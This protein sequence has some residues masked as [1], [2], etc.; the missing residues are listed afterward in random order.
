MKFSLLTKLLVSICLVSNATGVPTVFAGTGDGDIESTV[1]IQIASV[2]IS[3]RTLTGPNTTAQRRAGRILLPVAAVA[4]ALGDVLEVDAAARTIAVHRQTGAAAD[5]DAR[6][7]RIRE[8]GAIV[9][10]VSNGG[11][12]AFTPNVDSFLIPAEIA[13]S[14]FDIAIRYDSDKN[15][16]IVD[17]GQVQTAP[18]QTKGD[19]R[20][21][22]LYQLDYEYNLNQYGS[23]PSHDLILNA[24]GRIGDGRFTFTS[25]SGA[26]A[27]DGVALRR[28]NFTLDRPNGQQYIAG[29][30]GT[31]ANLQFLSAGIRGASARVYV[32]GATLTAF[33]GR[34]YSGLVF[35][36][37]DPLI[38][39]DQQNRNQ[40]ARGYDTSVFG[41]SATT[42]PQVGG[43]GAKPFYFSAGAL[44]FSSAN[45]KGE[46]VTGAVNYDTSRL[47][48]QADT[49]YGKFDARMANGS[50]VRGYGAAVDVSGTF[51]LRDDLA[52]Q[53]RFTS[54]SRNFLGP[55]VGLREPLNLQA[56]GV[57]WSPLKWFST[58]INGS[59]ARRPGDNTQNN[60]YLTASFNITPGPASPRFSFSHTESSTSQ[61]RSAQ[62]T[63]FNA[64]QDFRRLRVYLNV[65]RVRNN[66]PATV[67]SQV[68]SGYSIND[69]NSVEASQGFGSNGIRNG[70]FDWRTSNLLKS[71]FSFSVGGGYNYSPAS[72]LST[73]QRLAASVNLPKHTS[74][75]INYYKTAQGF[76]MLASLRGS[77]FKRKNSGS[78]VDSPLSSLNSYANVSGRVYQD[79]N[80]NGR[81]DEGVDKPQA[82]VKVRVDGNR[83]VVSD[84]NGF[85]EFETIEAGGHKVFL[86]L[87]SVRADLTLLGESAQNTQL[88][89]GHD[90]AIDFRLV[91]TGR[92]S[93]R[94][95]LDANENGKF[96]DGEK[97]LAD[98]RVVTASGRDTLTDADGNFSISDLVPGEHTFLI[99]EKTLPEK[100]V[101]AEKPVAV[102]VFPGRETSDVHL[103]VIQAPAEI[104]RFTSKKN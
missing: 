67:N 34:S 103:G 3:G 60:N 57:T 47:R 63:N 102:Q 8:N 104:K 38:S 68:G 43:R 61:I 19:H 74:F 53:G 16:V 98:V 82:D 52:V 75:Q 46:F 15:A 78:Y 97:P 94:V 5:F 86:D 84:V 7:G 62:F 56:A 25:N 41:F 51:Q 31:G 73:F 91:R 83:Y 70:Q 77:L 81:F 50:R 101:P 93:G 23:S 54:I 64:S 87:L 80:Q 90:S 72:G 27:A 76:T 45:R 66:G 96:D 85:Y 22:E 49:A 33:G 39:A 95:W 21:A 17:R 59:T 55:Q 24:V 37:Y 20:A 13:A 88:L 71:R 29:D 2:I 28:T 11:E 35:P 48:L 14:L 79:V 65:T 30:F 44:R 32:R 42:V 12:L 6:S 99:D 100:T 18:T 26:T 4:R 9:L 10:S 89:P 36:I 1:Q 92:I 40:N 69:H 58:S